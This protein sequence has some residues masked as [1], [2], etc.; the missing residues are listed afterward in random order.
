M[1]STC[2]HFHP[3]RDHRGRP[4]SV[5][6]FHEIKDPSI[7]GAYLLVNK[8]RFVKCA[9]TGEAQRLSTLINAMK[10]SSPSKRESLARSWIATQ[11][12]A[13]EA[14]ARL[15][16]G[17]KTMKLMLTVSWIFFLF[18]F[19]FVPLYV[20]TAG[21][22]PTIILIAILMVMVAIR[23]GE[24]FYG[25]HKKLYPEETS[26]RIESL[27]KMILCPPASIRAADILTRKCWPST[28]LLFSRTF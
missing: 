16:H 15:H 28:A 7:N 9:T 18:L 24:L 4:D 27:V 6:S 17:Q 5:L 23:I 10:K 8:E 21:L 11:F 13:D 1:P 3:E 20:S 19:V 22:Q 25:A 14:A 26:E 12:D 2:K